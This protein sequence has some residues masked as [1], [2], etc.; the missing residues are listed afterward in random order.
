V[1]QICGK[2]LWG[3]EFIHVNIRA[4]RRYEGIFFRPGPHHYR[5]DVVTGT[6]I[7]T[8]ETEGDVISTNRT[9]LLKRS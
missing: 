3:L 1:V 9:L 7:R 6:V 4:V 5:Q 2:L 8:V